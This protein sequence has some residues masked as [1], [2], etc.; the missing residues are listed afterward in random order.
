M[1]DSANGYAA[2]T[3]MPPNRDVLTVEFKVNFVRPA[4]GDFFI[5]RA[6]VVNAGKRVVVSQGTVHGV[7]GETEKLVAT[8]T[9]TLMSAVATPE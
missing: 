8:M 4:V 6:K 3:L 1:L 7:T 5:A 9:A 2:F